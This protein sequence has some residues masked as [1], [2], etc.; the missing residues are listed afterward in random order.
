MFKSSNDPNID[1]TVDLIETEDMLV[2]YKLYWDKH[3]N[4][5]KTWRPY[6]FTCRYCKKKAKHLSQMEEH[7]NVCP[8]ITYA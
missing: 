6:G 2:T 3:I 4:D 8:K 7:L 1:Y 5:I